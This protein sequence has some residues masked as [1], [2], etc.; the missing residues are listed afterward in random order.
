VRPR[1]DEGD[2]RDRVLTRAEIKALWQALDDESS[3]IADVFRVM[4]L[5]GQRSGEVKEMRWSEVDLDACAEMAPTAR[6]W[7]LPGGRTKNRQP[8]SVPLIGEAL[9]IVRSRAENKA[10]DYVFPGKDGRRPVADLWAP[11]VRVMG[12]DSGATPHDLQR[13]HNRYAFAAE[14]AA[15]LTR[16]DRRVREIVKGETS[17]QRVVQLHASQGF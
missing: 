3:V 16:W 6:W 13:T 2:G 5:T 10:G 14:K 15:A 11:F 4:L 17:E 9:R 7:L 12:E 8:H 1:V